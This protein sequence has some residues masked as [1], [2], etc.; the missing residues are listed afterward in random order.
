MNKFN[1]QCEEVDKK[2]KP[3]GKIAPIRLGTQAVKPT[4]QLKDIPTV[5]AFKPSDFLFDNLLGEGAFGK[6][7]KC[8]YKGK[9]ESQNPSAEGQSTTS[10]SD[11]SPKN[12]ERTDNS[13]A[14]M[15]KQ[16]AV[17]DKLRIQAKKQPEFKKIT[18][19]EMAVK[20]QSKYQLVKSKQV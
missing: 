13:S 11:G 7:R 6:V 14:M 5:R 8:H 2:D 12:Q 1:S 20:L 18:E 10:S 19:T 3:I 16:M 15:K 9:V 17:N 4:N